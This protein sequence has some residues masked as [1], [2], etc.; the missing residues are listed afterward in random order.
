MMWYADPR[1]DH[2]LSRYPPVR[3]T[4]FKPRKLPA[5]E[6]TKLLKNR[7][8][9]LARTI[10]AQAGTFFF[11]NDG[12]M[13]PLKKQADQVTRQYLKGLPQQVLGDLYRKNDTATAII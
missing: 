9:F 3:L 8:I 2:R 13:G 12:A 5:K 7:D 1:Q 11:S 10:G 4:D 6:F